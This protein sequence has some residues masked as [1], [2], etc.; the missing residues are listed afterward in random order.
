DSGP[1]NTLQ[2]YKITGVFKHITTSVWI[3]TF[4]VEVDD[5]L[6]NGAV[7]EVCCPLV[8]C[9]GGHTDRIIKPCPAVASSSQGE[10]YGLTCRV[11]ST[12]VELNCVQQSV[13]G[14]TLLRRISFEGGYRSI[15]SKESFEERLEVLSRQGSKIYRQRLALIYSTR[16]RTLCFRHENVREL[17]DSSNCLGGLSHTKA[18]KRRGGR[19]NSLRKEG[20]F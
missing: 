1:G 15:V 20:R 13:V 12:A 2:D 16:G 19:P 10:I 4:V 11:C 6:L 8:F 17:S 5:L 9:D 3:H 18:T 7:I 14:Y